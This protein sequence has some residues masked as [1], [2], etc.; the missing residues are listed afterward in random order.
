MPS[1]IIDWRTG[2][3]LPRPGERRLARRIFQWTANVVSVAAVVVIVMM[4]LA[5][6]KQAPSAPAAGPAPKV[7]RGA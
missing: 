5:G 1:P 4:L 3:G 6:A 2:A 7:W